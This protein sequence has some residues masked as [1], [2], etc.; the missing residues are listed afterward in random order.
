MLRRTSILTVL[1]LCLLAATAALAEAPPLLPVSG[2]L[3]DADGVPLDGDI[4]LT[5]AL[6]ADATGGTALFTDTVTVTV[7]L[8]FFTAYAGE[9]ASLDLALFAEEGELWLG[10]TLEGEDEMEPRAL[11]ATAP[12]AGWAEYAGLADDSLALGGVDAA[13]Y[14]LAT[15]DADTLE[16][17]GCL[18]G[19]IVVYDGDLG[20]WFCADVEAAAEVDPLFAAS[21]AAGI[22]ATNIAEWTMAYGWGDHSVAGY[23]TTESDPVF[24]ASAA[25]GVGTTDIDNWNTAYGWGDHGAAGYL[26]TESDPVFSASDAAGIGAVDIGNWN[27]AYGW[28]DHGA[29][30][31][32]TTESDPVFSASDAAGIGAVDIGNWNTAY[33]WGDHGAAGYLT[34]ETDPVFSA[35]DVAGVTTTD[36]DEWDQAYGWGD[37]GAAGYLTSYTETD[38]VYGASPASGIASGDISNWNTAYGW[39]DHGAAGYLTSYTETDPVYGA[40]AASGIASGDITAWNTAYGWGDHGAAGYLTSYTE[41]DPV[42][43]SSEAASITSTDTSNWAAAYGW[44]NHAS[45][46]YVTTSAGNSAYVN[47]TGDT[48]SG[49]LTINGNQQDIAI[50]NTGSETL[51]GLTIGDGNAMGSQYGEVLYHSGDEHL[52]FNVDSTTPLMVLT[53]NQTVGIGISSPAAKFHVSGSVRIDGTLD[54]AGHAWALSASVAHSPDDISATWSTLS[55]D[56]NTANYDLPFNIEVDGTNY[57]WVC[58]ST[59]GF[60]EFK[61]AAGGCYSDLSNDALPTSSRSGPLVA[62]YWDDLVTEGTHIRYGTVGTTGSRVAIFDYEARQFGNTSLDVR[63]QIQV[64]EQSD[65]INVQYRDPMHPSMNGQSATIGFQTDGGSYAVAY[66]VVANGKVLDDNRDNMSWSIAP[67]R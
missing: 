56:D 23:L 15:D 45:A 34:T 67:I 33:G 4:D 53:D 38:P 7:D 52:Q 26:T 10:L 9:N 20:A 44:G 63:F 65:L 6:Y 27:T 42:F 39:G 66:P 18:D 46:G 58:I 30:G 43:G 57:G 64:H 61:T 8:G 37:H 16:D 40:S 25:A 32:L 51:G 5:V 12:W 19:Q 21:D 62:A 48:M 47:V 13:E 31:Y 59:N 29:A 1:A 14:L 3:A 41:T 60:I 22:S 24:S 11:V 50:W 55:G 35:S 49:A 28:G 36:I 54:P 17:L 2:W